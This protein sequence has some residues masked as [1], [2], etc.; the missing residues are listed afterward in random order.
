[1]EFIRAAHMFGRGVWFHSGESGIGTAAYLHV[2]AA[3]A[4][5]TEPSQSLLRWHADDVIE[6]G[7]VP[8]KGGY[9]GVPAGVG[10]GVTLD[11]KALARCHERFLVEGEWPS[12]AR[13]L[14]LDEAGLSVTA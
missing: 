7:I 6:E 2:A 13:V 12:A 1:I 5:I 3:T 10:L 14:E 4:E 9:L 11:R 8:A